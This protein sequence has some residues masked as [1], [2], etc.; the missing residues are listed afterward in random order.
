VELTAEVNVDNL[1]NQLK[2][3]YSQYRITDIDGVRIDFDENRSWVHL[4]KSNTEPIIR[5]YAEAANLE[6]A[7]TLAEEIKQFFLQNKK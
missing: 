7:D 4:R 1:L 5:I 6:A 2:S 3:T